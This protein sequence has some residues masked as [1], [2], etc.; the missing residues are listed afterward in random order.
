[1]LQTANPKA[2]FLLKAL[3][4]ENPTVVEIGCLRTAK[5][6]L[7]DGWSTYYLAQEVAKAGGRLYFVDIN[8][9][10][11]ALATE[12]I[13]EFEFTNGSGVVADGT[14]FLA[15]WPHA[16]KIDL[17]YLDSSDDPRDTLRQAQAA[18]PHLARYARIVID[19]VQ[20]IGSNWFGKGSMAIPFLIQQGWRCYIE[21][22]LW[23]GEHCWA[24]AR[25]WR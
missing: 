11:V 5:E 8:P 22:T 14:A 6:D 21:P 12:A 15:A 1:M 20:P 2:T 23:Q 18:L 16:W 10:A 4:T 9:Q 19:D 3:I 25:L 7:T 24:M 13:K 17:L